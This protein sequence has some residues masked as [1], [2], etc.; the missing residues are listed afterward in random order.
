MVKQYIKRHCQTRE[1]KDTLQEIIHRAWLTTLSLSYP[2]TTK[3]GTKPYLA[4]L[5]KGLIKDYKEQEL[6]IQ[7]LALFLRGYLY[8]GLYRG[9]KGKRYAIEVVIIAEKLLLDNLKDIKDSLGEV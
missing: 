5:E 8:K 6:D 7:E 2:Y 1:D 9:R 3:D 4:K